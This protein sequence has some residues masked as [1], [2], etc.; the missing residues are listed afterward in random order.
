ML[1]RTRPEGAWY[2]PR[3]GLAITAEAT[4]L[5]R[6]FR[7]LPAFVCVPRPISLAVHECSLRN[8]WNW[9]GVRSL[10]FASI[11]PM[12]V[13]KSAFP[14]LSR[15]PCCRTLTEMPLDS[16]MRRARPVDNGQGTVTSR[17]KGLTAQVDRR[18]RGVGAGGARACGPRA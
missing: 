11:S 1:G 5:L 18:P 15:V 7:T 8:N 3:V 17:D 12:L 16:R 4:P 2:K 14:K 6:I 9:S 10:H 13:L